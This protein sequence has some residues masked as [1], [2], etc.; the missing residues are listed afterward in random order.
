M[1]GLHAPC[2]RE[3]GLMDKMLQ[4]VVF[5]DRDGV[6]NEDS[7]DYIKTWSEFRFLPGSLEALKLLNTEGFTTIVITNQSI[8]HRKMAPEATLREIHE[9]MRRMVN[10]HGGHITDIFFCPHR[11]EEGCQCRKPKPGLIRQ[12]QK[13]YPM[14]RLNTWMV[15]DSV[16][17]I[18]CARNAGCGQAI[19]VRTGNGSASERILGER[20]TPPDYVADTL[21]DAVNWITGHR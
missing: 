3:S 21:F 10:Q 11:P 5:L 14:N 17:D 18:D 13:M 1:C 9:N 6:I 15:G 19:L 20:K 4:K 12:A 7:P 8:I 2:C 16:K